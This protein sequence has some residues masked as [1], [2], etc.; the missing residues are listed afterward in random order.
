M[1]GLN[2]ALTLRINDGHT[3]RHVT[4]YASGLKFTKVAPGGHQSIDYHLDLPRNTFTNLGPADQC[5]LY[6]ARTGRTIFGAGYLEN[7]TPVDGPDGQS[8]DIT[9][10]GGMARANDET[11][12][13]IYVDQ[14]LDNWTQDPTSYSGATVGSNDPGL[15]IQLPG[16]AVLATSAA[17][18]AANT[19]FNRAGM[20][21]GAITASIIGGKTDT[22]Y[23]VGLSTDSGYSAYIG[24]TTPKLST[25]TNPA[26]KWVGTD[27]AASS[28]ANL[29]LQ[30]IGGPTNVADDTTWAQLNSLAVAG[31][32]MTPT[33]ALLTGA[34][35]LGSANSVQAYQVASDLL[36]R[37]LTFCDP[38]T[39]QIDVTTFAIDQL[40]YPD[41]TKAAGVLADLA[42]FEPDFLDEILETLP[43]GLHRFNYRAW[44]TTPRYVV[45]VRDGWRQTGSD[46]DLCNRIAVSWNGPLAVA[47][48]SD[49]QVTVITAAS[50]GLVGLGYPVDALGTRVK[51]ADPE[52]LPDGHGSL[53][54]ALQIGGGILRDKIN[55]PLAGTITV[56][57]RIVDLLTGHDV[58]PWEIEPGYLCR[59][60]ELGQD[61][62]ISQVDYDDDSVSMLLTLGR[63]PLTPEQRIARLAAA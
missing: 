46:S 33:G 42:L 39:A 25:A 41:G 19:M 45:S 50:L 9:A 28:I 2:G 11:R 13:L 24:D 38:G 61:L 8:Y 6:D 48:R 10:Q 21:L 18:I 57:R 37:L 3:D 23:A 55:P 35:G 56:R 58:E 7:P 22:G 32:R 44:P 52:T 31:Q 12:A 30:R 43:N 1:P 62:R 34:A 36:G 29:F 4:R 40:A 26:T 59:V 20:G 16:G 60:R 63:P 27:F 17:A 5:W 49:A 47:N 54:N 51:D 53:A 14:S 15:R